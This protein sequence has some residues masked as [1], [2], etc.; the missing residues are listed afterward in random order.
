MMQRLFPMNRYLFF[1]LW[2]LAFAL[3]SQAVET[4]IVSLPANLPGV[5][6]VI[7]RTS[8]QTNADSAVIQGG[9]VVTKQHFDDSEIRLRARAPVNVPQVQIWAGLH[10]R[11]R[12]SRYVF[13]LRGGNDNDLYIARYAPDGRA[14]FLGFAPLDFKPQPGEWYRFRVVTMGDRILIFL[15]D[16]KLPRVNVEDRDRLWHEGGVC[17]GGGW[18]PAEFSDLEA[19]PLTGAGRAEISA[20][21]QKVW[22][23]PVPDK[24]IL[25]KIQR[26][27][28]TP[29]KVIALNPQRTEISL[30]GNWLFSP[31]YELSTGRNPVGVDFK[32]QS[33]HVLAVPAFWTPALS[34][35]HGE[36]SFSDL[37]GLSTTKGVAESLFVQRIQKCDALTFDWRKTS[38]AWYRHYVDL[39]S[40]L[41][42]RHFELTFD[43]VAKVSEVWVNGKKVGAHVGMFGRANY[44]VTEAIKPG[45]N[46]IAVHVFSR[47]ESQAK[48]D[49]KVEG[50][51]VTVEVTSAMLYSLP[52]GMFQEDVAGIWQPVKLIAT[53]PISVSDVFVQPRLDGANIDLDVVNHGAQLIAADIEYLITSEANGGVLCS[54]ELAQSLTV[55]AGSTNHLKLT[56]PKI[57]PK[58]WSPTEP[59]LYTLQIRLKWRGTV[60]DE[61]QVHFGFRTFTVADGKLFLNGQPLWVRGANPFPNT[62]CPN[63]GEL[64][65]K[66]IGLA[67]DGNI[68]VTRSH[69]VPFTPAWLDAADEMGMAVSFEGT[70]PWLMLEGQPPDEALLKVWREEFLTLIHEYRNHPSLIMWTV[71]NEMKFPE[72]DQNN[73]PLLQKKWPILDGMIKAMREADPTRPIVAD[74]AYVRKDAYKG[75]R[76]VVQPQGYDDGDVDDVHRYY[77]WYT[78]SFF[79]LYDGEYNEKQ[80]PGR[81]LISQEMS[82]GYPNND[83][84]HATRFYLFKHYTPQAFVG[85]DAYENADPEVFLNRQAFMTKELAETLRRA[86]HDASA[87]VLL[88]SYFTWFQT[89]WSV[90]QI[91][92]WPAYYA[93]KTAMQPVLVSAELYGRHFYADST[94]QRRVCVINDAEDQRAISNGHLTWEFR[95]GHNVLSQGQVDLPKVDYYKTHWMDIDFAT[96]KNLHTPRMDGQLVL[97][98]EADGKILSE[99]NYA[100]VLATSEWAQADSGGQKISLWNPGKHKV[101]SFAG[102]SVVPVDSIQQADPKQLLVIGDLNGVTLTPVE[103]EQL[104]KFV[105]QGGRV[106]MLHPG[107]SLPGLFPEQVASFKAKEGEIVTLHIPESPVFSGISP[108]DLSWFD[109]GGRRLPAACAGVYRLTSGPSAV[110]LGQQCDIHGYL[111]NTSEIT[112]ISGT[113]LV[114][115]QVGKGQLIASEMNFESGQTDPVARR[116]F[117]NTISYLASYNLY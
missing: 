47:P 10:Q 14:K 51:A 4:T 52:H 9:Y 102:L 43:A 22:I 106:L 33:W 32:D 80:T 96:P 42:G 114:E 103:S 94:F 97:R 54:N 40:D 44:D 17:L 113:P 74:S 37:D 89:P 25:R 60:M 101:T 28:Y 77:G 64:A 15:N 29:A 88:F 36:T 30:D 23:P 115:I 46:L 76:A 18:L 58:L 75:Y 82:T 55:T 116:L 48:H 39:P 19:R 26:A 16:E 78:D 98:L 66:F 112:E 117:N 35:L 109:H 79:H 86:S 8:V 110:A 38:S 49:N 61:Y 2:L 3:R 108:L 95:D 11:D 85:D 107:K 84:G 87:G 50:I 57:I 65:R 69:I 24:E 34:W 67:R 70:W 104:R 12:D 92:P 90:D 27:G 31:D 62:L 41:G 5:W 81:P 71:N 45:H 100:V 83:D 68:R 6:S 59:N 63:D 1:P 53:A 73:L 7:G 72:L 56:T 93:M 13:A 20:I 111:K 105:I 99:N 91:K 21:G